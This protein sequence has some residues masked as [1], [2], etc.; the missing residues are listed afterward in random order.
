MT[1]IVNYGTECEQSKQFVKMIYLSGIDPFLEDL[2]RLDIR[3]FCFK[4]GP[5]DTPRLTAQDERP[6]DL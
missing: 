1:Q 4:E 5:R 2:T 3:I 6:E